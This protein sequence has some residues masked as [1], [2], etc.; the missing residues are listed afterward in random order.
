[1]AVHVGTS[2]YSFPEWRGS[3][4]PEGLGASEM[5]PYYAARLDTVEINNTF[6]RM[7]SEKV[8]EG[9]AA[10]VGDGFRFALKAP[11]TITHIK[12]LKDAS[13]PTGHFLRT[14][15]TLAAKLGPL[16]V[17]LP[18]NLKKDLPR[19]A[20]FLELLPAPVGG[21]IPI[22]A[23]FEFRHASW[24]EDDVYAALAAKGAALC[25]AEDDELETPF[26]STAPWGYLRLRKSD[27][28]DADLA[29]KAD[30]LGRLEWREAFVYFKHEEEG[31]GPRL[32][33]AFRAAL[34]GS[35]SPA[36]S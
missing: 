12:R 22:R 6:Y 13:E 9:W 14:A 33:A 20:E 8:L 34:S 24:F 10:E 28:S 4:Y 31:R 36:T 16:L 35:A 27:Y 3:F 17:Q 29:A 32:A 2:G 23:A 19:L 15:S 26:L 25:L 7:P 21:E 11:R 30:A 1:M 5:L 18:P